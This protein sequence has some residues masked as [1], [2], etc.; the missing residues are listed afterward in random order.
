MGKIM[1][2]DQDYTGGGEMPEVYDELTKMLDNG[3]IEFNS[4]EYVPKTNA[5]ATATLYESALR[6]TGYST[7]LVDT[8]GNCSVQLADGYWGDTESDE[9]GDAI[10]DM[11]NRIAALEEGGGSGMPEVYDGLTSMLENQ[12]ITYNPGQV[13]RTDIIFDSGYGIRLT[14]DAGGGDFGIQLTGYA[15]MKLSDQSD[16]V[17]DSGYWGD[18]ED[19]YLISAFSSICDRIAALEQ[20][21]GGALPTS[22]SGLTQELGEDGHIRFHT[23][24]PDY[25]LASMLF[26]GYHPTVYFDQQSHIY[27]ADGWGDTDEDDLFCAIYDMCER[28]AS[29]E[30]SGI[31][32]SYAGLTDMLENSNITFNNEFGSP[33]MAFDNSVIDVSDGDIVKSGYWAGDSPSEIS[34]SSSLKDYLSDLDSYA[35]TT[36]NN[37]NE[38]SDTV[39]SLSDNVD[40]LDSNVYGLTD[41]VSNLS[42]NIDSVSSDLSDLAGNL[43]GF[44]TGYFSFVDSYTLESY[45]VSIY[46]DTDADIINNVGYWGAD[47]NNANNGEG[48]QTNSIIEAFQYISNRLDDLES[49]SVAD[50][51]IVADYNID[52]NSTT[53]VAGGSHHFSGTVTVGTSS[54][55]AN[56]KPLNICGYTI[57]QNPKVMMTS[58]Y[59]S[60]NSSSSGYSFNYGFDLVNLSDADVILS[61]LTLDVMCVVDDSIS[62]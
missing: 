59:L 13:G 25:E 47:S 27:S 62:V 45:G 52:L 57:V 5:Q 26:T 4:D 16:I 53:I 33:A 29:L 38:L 48:L 56:A 1:Y 32:D 37:L 35:V 22:Y 12:N 21:G 28:I 60:A 36:N 6:L 50:K 39:S 51:M 2:K 40:S 17:I 11:C 42:D 46:L 44:T 10:S 7:V 3:N 24:D 15:T 23:N 14:E 58:H 49:V 41:D 8:I 43:A 19:G 9:L 34:G 20:S 31:P 18:T 55:P 61:S 54:T 30:E